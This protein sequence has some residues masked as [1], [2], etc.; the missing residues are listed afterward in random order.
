MRIVYTVTKRPHGPIWDL[1]L[2]VL[3][4]R[5]DSCARFSH[6]PRA[7]HIIREKRAAVIDAVR[8]PS[9]PYFKRAKGKP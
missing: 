3:P 1:H 6:Q 9:R 7:I 2:R 8:K 4:N 5:L